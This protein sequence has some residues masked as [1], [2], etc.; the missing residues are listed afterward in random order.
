MASRF[1]DRVGGDW[2]YLREAFGRR[3]AFLF[4]WAAFWIVRPGNIGAM[5]VTFGEYAGEFLGIAW[6]QT[7]NGQVFLGMA[8]FAAL[9]FVN[10]R[11]LRAGA[12]T[13]RFLTLAKI[14]GISGLVLVAFAGSPAESQATVEV[15]SQPAGSSSNLLVAMMFIMFAF[16]GWNDVAFVTGE[17]RDPEKNVLR[18]LFAGILIVTALYV[19]LNAGFLWTLGLGGVQQSTT[20]ATD[21]VA[22]RLASWGWAGSL[23]GKITSLLVCVSCLGAINAMLITSPRIFF[24]AIEDWP[25]CSKRISRLGPHGEMR[26]S[27]A[28]TSA[29]TLLLLFA[30]TLYSSAFEVIVAVT[31]PWFWLFLALVPAAMIVLRLRRGKHQGYVAP[32]FPVPPLILI[33]MCLYLTWATVSYI[34]VRGFW[35]PAGGM[36]LLMLIGGAIATQLKSPKPDIRS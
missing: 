3:I 11:G 4:A 8:A 13:L 6:S 12:G 2:I 26:L 5:C 18:A 22:V 16:G 33:A 30:S 1:R 29:V 9:T 23:A 36:V 34:S 31:A 35:Y 19:A 7:A 27:L 17:I 20:V 24:A 28:A 15:V 21:A 14:V 25:A 32:L 10:L